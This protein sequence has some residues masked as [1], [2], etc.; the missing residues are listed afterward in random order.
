MDMETS[1]LF[2]IK[3][4]S[5]YHQHQIFVFLTLNPTLVQEVAELEVGVA[6]GEILGK[7]LKEE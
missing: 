4:P 2:K 7:A 1:V 5:G 6:G 3:I